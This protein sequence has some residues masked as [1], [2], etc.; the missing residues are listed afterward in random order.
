MPFLTQRA[1]N[2][3]YKKKC[4]LQ[5]VYSTYSSVLFLCGSQN[6]TIYMFPQLFGSRPLLPVVG[7]CAVVKLYSHINPFVCPSTCHRW[8]HSCHPA[9]FHPPIINWHNTTISIHISTNTVLLFRN[10]FSFFSLS[11]P[12]VVLLL[13]LLLLPLLC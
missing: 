13:L 6:M 2:G 9:S 8:L 4:T 12:Y 3:Q 11:L 10:I 7:Y 5:L 1:Y